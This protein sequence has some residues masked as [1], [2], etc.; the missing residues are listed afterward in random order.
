[1][2]RIGRTGFYRVMLRGINRQ[3]IF[4][5][6]RNASPYPVHLNRETFMYCNNKQKK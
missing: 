1:M 6:E 3:D 2:P 4:E 5:E